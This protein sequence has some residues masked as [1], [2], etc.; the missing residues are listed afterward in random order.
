MVGLAH[1][2][3]GNILFGS[4]GTA[5]LWR[6]RFVRDPRDC[7]NQ[8][9]KTSKHLQCNGLTS[10]P[11]SPAVGHT[12]ES[13]LGP[14]KQLSAYRGSNGRSAVDAPGGGCIGQFLHN[15]EELPSARPSIAAMRSFFGTIRPFRSGAVS[16]G[17]GPRFPAR[18]CERFCGYRTQD[19]GWE[20][21]GNRTTV[22]I[23]CAADCTWDVV[24]RELKCQMFQEDQR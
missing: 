7:P 24:Q 2:T 10:I 15:T 13:G 12:P 8:D 3:C 5:L 20:G 18:L 9:T 21:G 11:S 1:S 6:C 23:E 22:N 19:A 4:L 16:L 14:R 17:E